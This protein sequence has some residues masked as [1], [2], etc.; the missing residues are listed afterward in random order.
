MRS[1][2]SVSSFRLLAYAGQPVGIGAEDVIGAVG[3]QILAALSAVAIGY[4]VQLAFLADLA[5]LT[6]FLVSVPICLIAYL[7]VIVGVFRVTA[8]LHLVFSLLR[9]Y[10]SFP[11]RL[12]R[13]P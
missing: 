12:R 1:S 2:H 8:P 6:R 10:S 4:M 11:N 3:P 5:Q 9:D 13:S 7:A